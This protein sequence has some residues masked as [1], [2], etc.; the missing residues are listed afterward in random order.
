MALALWLTSWIYILFQRELQTRQVPVTKSSRPAANMTRTYTHESAQRCCAT[1]LELK[2]PHSGLSLDVATCFL[3]LPRKLS[4]SKHC[5]HLTVE[6]FHVGPGRIV[7]I[8]G[9]GPVSLYIYI[10]GGSECVS[11]FH[12]VP[13]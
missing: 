11:V 12:L 6:E 13:I 8:K 9:Q 1:D 4:T 3:G 10:I 5:L 7:D 2:M